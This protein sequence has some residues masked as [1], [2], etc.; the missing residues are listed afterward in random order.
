MK[1]GGGAMYNITIGW[2]LRP[3]KYKACGVTIVKG[4]YP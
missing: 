4:R 3:M 2:D 1:S